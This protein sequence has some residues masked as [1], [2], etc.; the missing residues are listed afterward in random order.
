LY[1]VRVCAVRF[2]LRQADRKLFD[3]I[4][5]HVIE[6]PALPSPFAEAEFHD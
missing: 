3:Q 5:R 4:A 1:P 2:G 6:K